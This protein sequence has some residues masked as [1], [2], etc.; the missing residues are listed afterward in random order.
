M[1]DATREQLEKARLAREIAKAQE[2]RA[3]A[4][5]AEAKA[6]ERER[7]EAEGRLSEVELMERLGIKSRSTVLGW[8]KKGCPHK[9]EGQRVFYSLQAVQA[10]RSGGGMKAHG[11]PRK[12]GGGSEAAKSLAEM[13]DAAETYSDLGEIS[14]RAGALVLSGD[15]ASTDASAFKSLLAEARMNAKAAS[16]EPDEEALKQR[17]LAGRE[18]Y[19]MVR[20]YEGIVCEERR[21]RVLRFLVSEFNAD[22]VEHPPVDTGKVAS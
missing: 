22:L 4:R 5:S 15:L 11:R 20:A 8:R 9:I 19:A 10:W 3:K 12:G 18:A 21:E 13:L 6:N 2:A 7:V 16:E 14:K 1:T 17:V